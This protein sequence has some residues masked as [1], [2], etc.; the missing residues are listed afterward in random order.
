MPGLD[1]ID[2]ICYALNVPVRE[3]IIKAE[4]EKELKA[5]QQKLLKDLQPY[6]RKLDAVAKQIYGNDNDST[7][8]RDD[9]DRNREEELNPI[10]KGGGANKIV[11]N[12]N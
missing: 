1:L 2:R 8:G 7:D 3:V 6:F 12:L 5:E 10:I 11:N 4:L 9:E